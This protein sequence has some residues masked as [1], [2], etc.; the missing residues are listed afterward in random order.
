MH[1]ENKVSTSWNLV[2]LS[3]TWEHETW[4]AHA[5]HS[6]DVLLVKLC[7]T[8]Y[9]K[10]KKIKNKKPNWIGQTA[11]VVFPKC[12]GKNGKGVLCC[13]CID[14]HHYGVEL[15][16]RNAE[17]VIR[18]YDALCWAKRN[19]G[20]LWDTKH[21]IDPQAVL[22]FKVPLAYCRQ[23]MARFPRLPPAAN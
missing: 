21:G 16:P 4:G 23:S 7:L 8:R 17:I 10:N 22:T 5:K 9:P 13:G 14:R 6:S 3:D 19:A 2:P 18:G 20:V 11:A 12:G 15:Q 1:I